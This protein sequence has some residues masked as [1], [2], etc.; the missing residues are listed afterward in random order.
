MNI[1]INLFLSF[2][3]IGVMTFGGGY[4]MLPI[5]QKEVCDNKKW[6]TEDELLDYYAVG[7]ITPG[8]IAINTATFVG[9]KTG[10]ITGG[11]F[12]SLGMVFPSLIII[13]LIAAFFQ[14]YASY[15]LV[16][17]ALA[18]IR[19]C[20]VA[21][22]FNAVIKLGKKSI[23]GLPAFVIFMLVVIMSVFLNVNPVFSVIIGGLIGLF[24]KKYNKKEIIK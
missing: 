13:T 22:I 5:L 14:N 23:K 11:I 8:I 6:V 1:N 3:K 4:A 18:A 19:I 17:N 7:Q 9:K 16:A 20:V 21:L 2:A 10:G 15:P 24:L 12:A